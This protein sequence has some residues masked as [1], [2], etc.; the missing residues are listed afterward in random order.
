VRLSAWPEIARPIAAAPAQRPRPVVSTNLLL[1][2]VH[3]VN[4]A[5]HERDV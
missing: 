5:C 3:L 2:T 4:V 1:P